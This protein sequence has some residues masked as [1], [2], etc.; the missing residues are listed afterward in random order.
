MDFL[1]KIREE[2]FPLTVTDP[3]QINSAAVLLAAGLIDG[4]VPLPIQDAENV[5]QPP[6][7]IAAI[8]PLG[9]AAIALRGATPPW[10]HSA[11]P[12]DRDG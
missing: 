9:R 11:R 12:S 1:V 10:L 8:I 6:A 4:T 5:I 2:T 3:T 7:V